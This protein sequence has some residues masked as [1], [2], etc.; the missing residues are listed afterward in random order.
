MLPVAFR[1]YQHLVTVPVCVGL[2]EARFAVDTGAGVTLLSKALAERVGFVP[3]DRKFSGRRMSG[4]EVTAPLGSVFSLSLGNFRRDELTVGLFDL[5]EVPGLEEIEGFLALDFFR[6]TPVTFDYPGGVIVPE[7]AESLVA[8]AEVGIAVDV[9]LR[10][11]SCTVEVFLAIEIPGRGAVLVEVDTG[12]DSV[13]LN[14]ALVSS[15][16]IDLAA[17]STRQVEGR[18]ETGHAYTR[19]FARMRGD[20]SITGAPTIRRGDPEVMVQNIIYDDFVGDAFLR[21]FI[22]TYDVPNARMIFAA[23]PRALGELG[24]GPELTDTFC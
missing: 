5:G 17:E 13:I 11:D 20:V 16:G 3:R 15:A 1:H 23:V 6:S 7:D 14:E 21:N 4:Q 18:D 8:R 2:T 9:R 12:S 22:F 19:Y 10:V 24:S